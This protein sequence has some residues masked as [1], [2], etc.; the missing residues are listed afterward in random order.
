[1]PL[2]KKDLSEEMFDLGNQ[3]RLRRFQ[4]KKQQIGLPIA[5]AEIV[6]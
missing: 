6:A 5:T 3:P 2:Q 4:C 1:M